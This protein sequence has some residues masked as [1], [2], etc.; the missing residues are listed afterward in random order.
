MWTQ[1]FLSCVYGLNERMNKWINDLSNNRVIIQLQTS[2]IFTLITE[3]SR[4]HFMLYKLFMFI[5]LFSTRSFTTFSCP[6]SSFPS[7][8]A[9]VLSSNTGIG[10]A[11]SELLALSCLRA[12][13]SEHSPPPPSS[14]FFRKASW[15]PL[16]LG[17]MPM[18]YNLIVSHVWLCFVSITALGTFV[19]Y[20]FVELFD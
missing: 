12:S 7:H 9:L 16:G 13:T 8:Q 6:L 17:V 20:I 2:F 5:H 18:F 1:G 19:N 15:S 14:D 10:A 11:S 4:T 3:D